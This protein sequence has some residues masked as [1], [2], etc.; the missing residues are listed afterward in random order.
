MKTASLMMERFSSRPGSNP[1][2]FAEVLEKVVVTQL[3]DHLSDMPS[4]MF[5]SDCRSSQHRNSPCLSY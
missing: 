5:Q 4:E 1:P 2:F 3:V